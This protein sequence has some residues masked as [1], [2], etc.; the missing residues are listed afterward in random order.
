MIIK[1]RFVQTEVH[2]SKNAQGPVS[3]SQLAGFQIEI[4]TKTLHYSKD[5]D[6]CTGRK[7]Y[8]T[9]E[10]VEALRQH[11]GYQHYS[12]F[13]FVCEHNIEIGD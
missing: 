13:T 8:L 12:D 6:G 7:W 5:L 9:R 11:T 1:T 2:C 3:Y 4:D 10:S